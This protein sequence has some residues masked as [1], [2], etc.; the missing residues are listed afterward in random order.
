MRERCRCGGN[1]A[2]DGRLKTG[3]KMWS[4]ATASGVIRVRERFPD[5]ITI[6][7]RA[8]INNGTKQSSL[9]RSPSPIERRSCQQMRVSTEAAHLIRSLT[10]KITTHGRTEFSTLNRRRIFPTSLKR[11]QP[12]SPEAGFEGLTTTGSTMPYEVGKEFPLGSEPS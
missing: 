4:N 6:F 9:G 11:T 8:A 2:T 12:R 7:P 1:G 5:G 10:K 3:A